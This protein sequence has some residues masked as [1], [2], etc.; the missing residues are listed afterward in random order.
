MRIS[1]A[2]LEKRFG[3]VE[4]RHRIGQMDPGSVYGGRHDWPTARAAWCK[5]LP[6]PADTIPGGRRNDR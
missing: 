3:L 5:I 2:E 4:R 1:I 6:A